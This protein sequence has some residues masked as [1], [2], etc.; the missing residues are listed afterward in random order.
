MTSHPS[1]T[2][3]ECVEFLNREA[4]MLD[5]RRLGEW[6]D[7][8]TED[9]E[10][11]APRRV[12]VEADSDREFSE[13]S[14]HFQEDWASLRTRV[15]RFETEYAWSED[16]PSRTRRLVSN[17]RV[18]P[19]G[20]DGAEIPVK[21]NFLL[22]RTRGNSPEAHVVAGEHHDILRRVDGELRLS[23]RRILLDTTILDM[24]NLS[25]FL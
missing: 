4:E 25:I 11:V 3:E 6:L 21:S 14:F 5:D 16:P 8:L 1:T 2:R 10:Y 20:Q 7:L 13:R 22:Y 12:T 9:I 23:S 15:E 19:A 17:V 24:G 18:D